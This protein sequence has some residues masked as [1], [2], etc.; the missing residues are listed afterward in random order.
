VNIRDE[1]HRFALAYHKKLRKGQYYKSPLD[2][3]AG[4]GQIKKR[5]LLK[6][7]GDIQKIRKASLDELGKVKS[8]TS[9]DT[10]IIYNYFH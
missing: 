2:K 4:I 6:H 7:F 1:A 5:N 9:K 3:I 10:K 8:I